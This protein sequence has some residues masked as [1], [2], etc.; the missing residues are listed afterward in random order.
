[1]VKTISKSKS[2]G[3]TLVELL[4]VITILGLFA[5]IVITKIAGSREKARMAAALR[6]FKNL[7]HGI[8]PVGSW[9]FDN[10]SSGIVVDG[11]GNGN[12]GMVFGATL[13]ADSIIDSGKSLSFDG[14]DTVSIISGAN[15]FLAN[16]VNETFL[17]WVKHNNNSFIL[18]HLLGDFGKKLLGNQWMFY[19]GCSWSDTLS[20]AGSNDGRWHFIA[21]AKFN[22]QLSSYVDGNL[23][24]TTVLTPPP[25]G[26]PPAI[27]APVF[28]FGTNGT[29]YYIGLIDEVRVYD[30]A[31]TSTEIQQYYAE[32]LLGRRLS[33][34]K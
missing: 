3:F 12:N 15:L 30:R 23:I 24:D 9:S 27:V 16:S 19:N 34:N 31:L 29:N 5:S 18:R 11:S 1:M 20:V 10:I 7:E 22:N 33:E 21:Y 28:D 4:V 8:E 17:L 32:S 13:S 25:P 14:N 2:I 26:C 6:N